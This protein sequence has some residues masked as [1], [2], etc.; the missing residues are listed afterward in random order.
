M[1][2]GLMVE[3]VH[4]GEDHDH[5]FSVALFDDQVVTDGAAGFGDV[6]DAGGEGALD[7]VGEGEEGVGAQSYIPAGGQPGS[8]VAFGE[9]LG[10][11]L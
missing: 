10:L 9:P 3:Q 1:V 11:L 4:A 8:L 5:V 2:F 6:S 7:G